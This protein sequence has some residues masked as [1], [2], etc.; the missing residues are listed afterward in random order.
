MAGFLSIY[1]ESVRAKI[2]DEKW[3]SFIRMQKDAFQIVDGL[4]I[5]D[6]SQLLVFY[7]SL[8]QLIPESSSKQDK[9]QK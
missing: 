5:E 6:R 7:R 2:G 8:M 9:D 1:L 3:T 4:R